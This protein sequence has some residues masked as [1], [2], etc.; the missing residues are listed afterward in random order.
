MDVRKSTSCLQHDEWEMPQF[1][2]GAG[3]RARNGT[4][5]CGLHLE[6]SVALHVWAAKQRVV[7]LSILISLY[8]PQI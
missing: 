6:N 8:W 1:S 3:E 4:Q 7:I 5:H 2:W